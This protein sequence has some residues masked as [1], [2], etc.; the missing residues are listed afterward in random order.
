VLLLFVN[1]LAMFTHSDPLIVCSQNSRHQ[2]RTE[3]RL[4]AMPQFRPGMY[5]SEYGP[6]MGRIP[7]AAHGGVLPNYPYEQYAPLYGVNTAPTGLSSGAG[8]SSSTNRPLPPAP[9]AEE[10][11]CPV[12][13]Y[14]LPS[15]DLPDAEER[16]E[17]HVIDCIQ[18]HSTYG[19]PLR[20]VGAHGTPPQRTTRRTGIFPYNAT[21]KDCVD[22]AECTICLEEFHVGVP[23]AR[24]ECLCRFHRSC[25]IAWFREH[26]GRCPVHQHDSF[27]Y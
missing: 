1:S 20:E 4:F 19:G 9:I 13:H 26:P 7:S 17:S 2:P 27:G 16:R 15:R 6:P 10:D 22:D 5:S 21:E 14:E 18:Q 24:L 12:C 25:I 11:E 8:P 23:M 3:P